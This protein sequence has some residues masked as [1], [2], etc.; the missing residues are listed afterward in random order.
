MGATLRG[1]FWCRTMCTEAFFF[2]TDV[3]RGLFYLQIFTEAYFSSPFSWYVT[4]CNPD[5]PYKKA[6]CKNGQKSDGIGESIF[7]ALEH[8][9]ERCYQKYNS[10]LKYGARGNLALLPHIER[11]ILMCYQG[12]VLRPTYAESPCSFTECSSEWKEGA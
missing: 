7:I 8:R 10:A 12:C 4:P 3:Y 9:F 1:V 5:K 11:Q 2:F 6:I